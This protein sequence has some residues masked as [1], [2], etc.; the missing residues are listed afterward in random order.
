MAGPATN[1][2]E[3]PEAQHRGDWPEVPHLGVKDALEEEYLLCRQGT[4]SLLERT[5]TQL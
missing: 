4:D 5:S 3:A 1:S 2:A